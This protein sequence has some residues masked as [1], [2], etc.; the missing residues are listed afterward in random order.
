MV[1]GSTIRIMPPSDTHGSARRARPSVRQA[2]ESPSGPAALWYRRVRPSAVPDVVSHRGSAQ[3]RSGAR[4]RGADDRRSGRGRGT[5]G[6][7]S[8]RTAPRMRSPEVRGSAFG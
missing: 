7:R 6:A 2:S 8:P 5:P 3:R 1:K 4:A